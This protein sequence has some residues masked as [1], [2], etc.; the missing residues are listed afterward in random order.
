MIPFLV[1]LVAGEGV[2]TTREGGWMKKE[3]E[4]INKEGR[5]SRTTNEGR[6]SRKIRETNRLYDCR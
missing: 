5:W 4:G 6:S 3:R 2:W 1:L